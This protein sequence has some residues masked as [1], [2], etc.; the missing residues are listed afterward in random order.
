MWS[1]AEH[2]SSNSKVKRVAEFDAV[3]TESLIF[4]S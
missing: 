1:M 2:N 4:Y 3:L